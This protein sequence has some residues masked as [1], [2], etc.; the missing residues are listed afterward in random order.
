VSFLVLPIRLECN[1]TISTFKIPGLK[2]LCTLCILAERPHTA[3]D[4]LLIESTHETGKT[5]RKEN[6]RSN[7]EPQ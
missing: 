2:F 3:L 1:D 7:Q 4:I 5:E 6:M